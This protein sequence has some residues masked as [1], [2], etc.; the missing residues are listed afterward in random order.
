MP[1]FK[2]DSLNVPDEIKESLRQLSN[3]V[4]FSK[5]S[6]K[7][8]NGH[9]FFGHNKILD[10]K[11]A[12]KYY[13]WGGDRAYHAEPKQL[14]EIK[15]ENVIDIYHAEMIGSDWAFFI[16]EYCPNGDL[17]GILSNGP[18]G[19]CD[20]LNI[21]S[22]IL[23]GLSHLHGASLL[24]RDLKPQNIF[25]TDDNRAVIGDFGS[26]KKV[27]EGRNSVPGSGHSILYRPPESI[28]TGDYGYPG[29]I[30]QSGIILYQLL[31]GYLPYE[32]TAWLNRQT[33]KKYNEINDPIDK[34]IFIDEVIKNKITRGKLLNL[35]SL[36][37]W[38]P[39]LLK[40]SISKAT[41]TDPTD[42]FGSESAFMAKLHSLKACVP[43]WCVIDGR[44]ILE[45]NTSFRLC[46][47]TD[48]DYIVQKRKTA[49][50]R[51]DNS[52]PATG[53][54]NQILAVESRI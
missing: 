28:Q 53:L 49:D 10:K 50:W 32:P 18:I 43:N 39:S 5:R 6:T 41:R 13:Y 34:S 38:V 16:T 44:I 24:H 20:G 17:D 22:Q 1:K 21:L 11:V 40:R 4:S 42:R 45:G 35:S 23:N 46:E 36:P 7:G 14:S 37:P 2:I 47:T 3:N 48:G 8:A 54:G 26:V 25:L 9:L 15:S 12:V 27:P 52:F 19:I 33:R 51:I 31:G 30:F 29:D